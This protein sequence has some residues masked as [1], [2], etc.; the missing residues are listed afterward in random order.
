MRL[1]STIFPEPKEVFLLFKMLDNIA[2][3]RVLIL[4]QSPY[5]TNNHAMGIAFGTKQNTEP[6]SLVKI[7]EALLKEGIKVY[8]NTLSCWV[9]QG[10]F[11]LN[12]SLTVEEKKP[13]SHKVLWFNFIKFLLGKINDKFEDL[14]V[15][16][17][18]KDAQEYEKFL[19][20]QKIWKTT[21][22]S[23]AA[24]TN[25]KWDYGY[26]FKEVNEHLKFNQLP[27]IDW[28]NSWLYKIK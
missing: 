7:K 11:L 22:P 9:I 20:K 14:P 28:D 4:G 15:I 27:E 8:D 10:V 5:P 18:G 19:S 2:N 25:T 26:V 21:H 24:R 17:I 1:S 23:L 13:N 6:A 12:T 3:I 16:L